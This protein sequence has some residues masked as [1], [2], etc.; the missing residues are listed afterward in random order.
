MTAILDT[1]T[2]IHD[3]QI[4]QMTT[5]EVIEHFAGFDTDTPL[6][7]AL[8]S[9]GYMPS[10]RLTDRPHVRNCWQGA[11]E[12][13]ARL[14]AIMCPF[15]TVLIAPDWRGMPSRLDGQAWR[16]ANLIFLKIGDLWP[17]RW[18]ELFFHEVWHVMSKKLADDLYNL[19]TE[20]VENAPEIGD[21]AYYDSSEEKLARC[22][23]H[24]AM[25]VWMGWYSVTDDPRTYQ[26]PSA[27]FAGIYS[28][29]FAEIVMAK[30]GERAA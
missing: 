4:I 22:F 2:C 29:Y 5:S 17:D 23:Q 6:T 26:T 10:L 21:A 25:S 12:E 9:T 11:V 20:V 30:E 19:C 7:R 3:G 1:V 8:E 28:G 18:I 14:A 24:W 16:D 15:A 13:I 27:V